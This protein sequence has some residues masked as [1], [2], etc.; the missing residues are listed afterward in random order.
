[1]AAGADPGS[2]RVAVGSGNPADGR[3]VRREAGITRVGVVGES[4]TGKAL[5][6][7]LT[8][9]GCEV[10]VLPRAGDLAGLADRQVVVDALPDVLPAKRALICRLE[11]VIAADAVI[12]T[13][14]PT[15]A[16]SQV[17]SGSAHPG[18]VIGMHF[19]TPELR[20]AELAG[21]LDPHT[22]AVASGL[23]ERVGVP[24]VWVADRPGFISASLLYGYLAQAVRMSQEYADAADI[25][26][27]MRLGCGYPSGPLSLVEAMGRDDLAAGLANLHAQYPGPRFAPLPASSAVVPHPRPTAAESSG[28][29]LVGVMGTG[30]MG[31][32][33]A[34]VCALAGMSVILAGRSRESLARAMQAIDTTWQRAQAKGRLTPDQAAAARARITART[35]PE[36]VTGVDLVIEAVAEDVIAK[37]SLFARLGEF[38]GA[39]TLLASTTS[40]MSVAELA[41][42]AG[43][44]ERVVG[45]HFFN[46]AAAMKLVEVV[47]PPATDPAVTARALAFCR[48]LGKTPVA[49]G[50]RAGFIVNALLFPYLNDAVRL[51]ESGLATSDQIDQVMKQGLGYPMGPF[52]LL[53]VVGLDVSVAIMD[54]LATQ[55]SEPSLRPAATLVDLVLAG[56][57]GRKTGRGLRT[58]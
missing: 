25:D 53:D 26:T 43:T 1:M 22:S 37:A 47:S 49:C 19:A 44:P 36:A 55:F 51:A 7:A 10:A 48:E 12:A 24:S 18:R 4:P 9:A 40:S 23:L 20:L 34:G 11:A 39:D 46:P 45:L 31:S 2:A 3:G 52:E 13:T 30:T 32:G 29:K 27:A 15:L 56:H 16:V 21:A 5:A 6:A 28:I 35:G 14:S 42:A 41:R 54:R 8:A 33:I 17:A 50:D 57:L 58:Y 38:L